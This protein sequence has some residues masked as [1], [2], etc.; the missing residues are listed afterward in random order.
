M[1]LHNLLYLFILTC[2]LAACHT[3]SH[4]A[5]LLQQVDSLLNVQPDS[6]QTLLHEWKDS[7]AYQPED[8]QMYYRLLCIKSDDKNYIPHTSDSLILPIVA[9]YKG[10]RDKTHLPEALYYAGR[11]YSDLDDAPRALEYFQHAIHV[12]EREGLTDYN[13]SSRIYSQMGTLFVY[14]ELYNEAPEMY[15]KAYQY[16]LLL[17][18]SANLVFDLRDIGRVF[19]STDRQDSA[20]CYYNRASKMALQIQDSLLLGMVYNEW[21]GFLIDWGNYTEAYKK[22]QT[23]QK[24][25]NVFNIDKAIYHN[26]IADYYYYTNQLDSSACYYAKNL[27]AHHSYVHKASAYEGLAKIAR[28]QGDAAKSLE[29]YKQYML[30]EDSL[31]QIIRTATID[32]IHMLYNYQQY[33]K[34]NVV[35]KR[36]AFKQKMLIFGIIFSSL[37]LV[38]ISS[39]FGSLIGVICGYF[40]KNLDN[41]LMRITDIFL[42]FPGIIFAIALVGILGGS[43]FNAILALSLISWPKF[44]L[45]ARSQT[46]VLKNSLF[47]KASII[48]GSSDFKIIYK[49]ILPNIFPIL[50][51]TATLNI[52]TMIMEIAGL[53]FLGLGAMPPSAE[54]GAMMSSGR[55]FLQIAPWMILA[56]AAAIF[57]TVLLFNL[58][59]DVLNDKLDPKQ[60]S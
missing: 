47:I 6:A 53:S 58:F 3:D 7:M 59:A 11:V 13:L 41:L 14:Q 26:N 50:L 36:Q 20:I 35:L 37:F 21:T 44:A 29:Y 22:L 40:G 42:A 33:K 43:I 34:E 46:L 52:G 28:R 5:Y 17:K 19:A 60:L 56:P 4:T 12:M 25:I 45:L 15:R 2:W 32:K 54:W 55:I 57:L 51:T 27:S 30:Y 10:Q 18:D 38:I 48:N 24:H 31:Q 8:L 23:I 1:K 16:D 49:H 9:Y 39:V